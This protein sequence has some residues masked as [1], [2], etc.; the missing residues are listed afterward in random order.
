MFLSNPPVTP[1]TSQ[2]YQ[3]DIDDVG[4]VMN[5]SRLWA[6]RPEVY[7]SFAALRMLL[8]KSWSLS[9]R[10]MGVLVCATASGLGDSYCSLAWGKK[11]AAVSDPATATAVLQGMASEKMTSRETALADWAR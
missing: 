8:M 7:Q 10:E 1:E 3:S 11:L 6:W 2:L 4:F 9:Q 5:L